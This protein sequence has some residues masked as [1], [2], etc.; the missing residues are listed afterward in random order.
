VASSSIAPRPAL[1]SNSKATSVS[2]SPTSGDFLT[3]SNSVDSFN[4][5][6]FLAV[7]SR[8]SDDGE[9]SAFDCAGCASDAASSP[10][11]GNPVKQKV[12]RIASAIF[13]TAKGVN[14]KLLHLFAL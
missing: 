13:P 8:S 7:M 9:A 6:S 1:C 5:A 2:M 3:F 14:C 10:N 11:A 12:A 4:N